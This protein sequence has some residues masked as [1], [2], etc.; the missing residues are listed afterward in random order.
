M[1]AGIFTTDKQPEGLFMAK[2]E[3]ITKLNLKKGSGNF[4]LTPNGVFYLTKEGEMGNFS[5]KSLF[6]TGI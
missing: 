2:G 1:N 3:I 5:I 6:S 4:Y